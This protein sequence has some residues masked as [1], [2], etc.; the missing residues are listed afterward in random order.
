MYNYNSCNL[1]NDE[2]LKIQKR[3][4]VKND[5]CDKNN[6][7]LIRI[8]YSENIEEKLISLL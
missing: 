7:K 3:D 1:V 6:I 8:K 4:K 2:F 5:Y